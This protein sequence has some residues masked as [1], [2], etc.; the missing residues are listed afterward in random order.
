MKEDFAYLQYSVFKL[1]LIPYMNKSQ[2]YCVGVTIDA[3]ILWIIRSHNVI[4]VS[5]SGRRLDQL[6]RLGHLLSR[7]RPWDKVQERRERRL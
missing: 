6:G 2:Y 3:T 1:L 7:L 5:S 4:I